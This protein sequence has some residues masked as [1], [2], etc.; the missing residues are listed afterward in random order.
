MWPETWKHSALPEI[1]VYKQ[2]FRGAPKGQQPAI[3]ERPANGRPPITEVS[4]VR[5]RASIE[6]Q[7]SDPRRWRGGRL[8][9]I[10][11]S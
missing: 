3:N 10:R 4:E 5:L 2:T 7:V 11:Q 1:E 8:A 9:P 6:Y